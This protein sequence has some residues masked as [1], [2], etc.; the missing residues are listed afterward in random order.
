MPINLLQDA[1]VLFFALSIISLIRQYFK[2][3][4][5]SW[6]SAFFFVLLV[7]FQGSGLLKPILQYLD[8]A[9][10]QLGASQI[11]L[12]LLIK[13]FVVV[14]AFALAAVLLANAIERRLASYR[15][16]HSSTHILITKLIK[17]S[18]IVLAIYTALGIVGLDLSLF[19]F[20]AGALGV[21]VA[22][23]LQ[24]IFSNFFSGFILLID[25]SVKPGDVISIDQGKVVGVVQKLNARY[26]SLKTREGKKHLIP[27]QQ[28]ITQTIENWSYNDSIIR[29]EIPFKVSLNTDL[30]L[31]EKILCDIATKTKRVL[32]SPAPCVR[33][34][35][36]IDNAVSLKLR[37]WIQD[38]EN[39][40]SGVQ[41]D[42]IFNAWKQF[43]VHAI[44]VPYPPR[45]V[46]YFSETFEQDLSSYSE[47]TDKN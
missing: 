37:V 31:V 5:V 40:L 39:G 8:Q 25:R 35:S 36:L 29:L 11:S 21:G 44:K 19:A 30:H 28:I 1:A 9:S 15:L 14:G 20:F 24:N 42:I 38:P 26:I 22:F 16:M 10:L 12:L 46:H 17:I 2:S 33:F 3:P 18:L 41:S 47:S 13:S 6:T 4:I 43:K 23:S 27:N 32:S 34:S 7:F 45:E